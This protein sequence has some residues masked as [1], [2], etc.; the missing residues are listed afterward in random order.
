MQV[1]GLVDFVRVGVVLTGDDMGAATFI[2]C[3]R[4]CAGAKLCQP[5]V[6]LEEFPLLHR[7]ARAVRTWKAG[8][9][10]FALVSFSPGPVFGCCLWSTAFWIFREILRAQSML[11]VVVLSA[12][13]DII[14]RALQ[15]AVCGNFRCVVQHFSGPSI[16][17]SSSS[18]AHAI[19]TVV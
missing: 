19:D 7:F 12:V 17:K 5:T 9:F 3:C 16:K 11:L 14:S 13:R 1:H 18:R 10:S 8:H 6:A 4:L 2:R 15:M